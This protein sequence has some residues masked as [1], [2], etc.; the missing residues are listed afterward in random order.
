MSGRKEEIEV[1]VAADLCEINVFK[2]S[3]EGLEISAY[4]KSFPLL[5]GK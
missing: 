3:S 1:T 5:T 2:I 4:F